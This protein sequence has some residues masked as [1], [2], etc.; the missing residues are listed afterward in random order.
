MIAMMKKYIIMALTAIAVLSSCNNEDVIPNNDVQ[1]FNFPTFTATIEGAATRTTLGEGNKVNWENGDEVALIFETEDMEN[2]GIYNY[3]V[4]P[5]NDDA[6]KATLTR[7]TVLYEPDEGEVGDRL[8]KAVYPASLWSDVF[9]ETQV[10]AGDDNIGFAPMYSH[11]WD[12]DNFTV[13]PTPETIEFKNAAAL[14]KITVPYAQMTSVRSITVSSDVAMHGNLSFSVRDYSLFI[15][16]ALDPGVNDHLILDCYGGNENANVEI[17]EGDSKT[18]YIALPIPVIA[19]GEKYGHLQIDVT[20]GTTTKSMRTTKADGIQVERNKI[21]SINFAENVTPAATTGT[22]KRTGD[23]DVD[24]VQLC[25]NG[26]KWATYNVGATAPEEYGGYF[27][28]GESSEKGDYSWGTYLWGNYNPSAAPKYGINKYTAEA[29]GGD[30]LNT[31]QA[32]DDPATTVWG[33]N[34]RTPTRAEAEELFDP[35]KCVWTWDSEKKGYTVTGLETGN[36]IFLPAAGFCANTYTYRTASC[37]YYW[38]SSV[39]EEDLRYAHR[40]RFD[41]SRQEDIYA[42]LT[43]FRFYGESVRAVLK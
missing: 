19:D 13:K 30:G 22:A 38:T 39:N 34:W 31:L 15:N 9:P 3:Q 29:D 17:P 35:S 20:D 28:W 5:D 8:S 4:T 14:L 6:S 10:Y 43:E 32:G 7:N 33:D 2:R 41:T 27:A 16:D 37:G 1:S 21:Y 12:L 40:F 42:L 26:P 24:W 11:N 18:F 36:T 25:V 23:F